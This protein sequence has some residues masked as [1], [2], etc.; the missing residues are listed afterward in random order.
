MPWSRPQWKH[1]ED[2]LTSTEFTQ[3][4]NKGIFPPQECHT[5]FS[6]VRL[7]TPVLLNSKQFYDISYYWIKWC[8]VTNDTLGCTSVIL[9]LKVTEEL[10][11]RPHLVTKRRCVWTKHFHWVIS[12]FISQCFYVRQM[13]TKASNANCCFN[14]RSTWRTKTYGALH[15]GSNRRK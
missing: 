3:D 6:P 11:I 9:C 7:L 4:S 2:W 14:L 10:N 8:R 15:I 12:C 5:S 13:T 1:I